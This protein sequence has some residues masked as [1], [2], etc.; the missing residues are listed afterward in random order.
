[1]VLRLASVMPNRVHADSTVFPPA[2][3]QSIS[4]AGVWTSW[5]RNFATLERAEEADGNM[6]KSIDR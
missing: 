1:V 3:P 5:F 6:R 4:F 2:K